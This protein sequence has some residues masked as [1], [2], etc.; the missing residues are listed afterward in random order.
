[1]P[2]VFHKKAPLIEAIK[3]L[4]YYYILIDFLNHRGYHKFTYFRFTPIFFKLLKYV[5]TNGKYYVNEIILN[6][7]KRKPYLDLEKV[8][9]SKKI[10]DEARESIIENLQLNIITV[11][12]HYYNQTIT[13]QDILILDSS[14]KVG[15]GYKLSLH[16]IISSSSKNLFYLNSRYS[17]SSAFHLYTALTS[18]GFLNETSHNKHNEL[19]DPKVYSNDVNFRIIGSHKSF[20]SNRVLRPIHCDTFEFIDLTPENQLNYLLTYFNPDLENIQL[21]TPITDTDVKS[22]D[23]FIK[24][25]VTITKDKPNKTNISA[26]LLKLVQKYHPTASLTSS[27]L[28]LYGFN[29]ENRKEPCPLS[30]IVHDGNNGFYVSEYHTGYLMRCHS[31]NCQHCVPLHIGYV[32]ECD[33]LIKNAI[34]VETPFLLDLDTVKEHIDQWALH[35]FI[36]AIK[37][38]MATGKTTT[39]KYIIEKYGFKQILWISHRQSLTKNLKGSFKKLGFV[40]YLSIKGCLRDYD[41]LFVQIDSIYRIRKLING[42]IKYAYPKY[43]LVIIDEI[44]GNLSHYNSPFLNTPQ[45][46]AREIFDFVCEIISYSGKLLV[47]DADLGSRTKL[48]LEH[49]KSFTLIHNNFRPAPKTFRITNERCIFIDAILKDL[50]S[51]HNVCI[52]SMS[53]TELEDIEQV[54]IQKNIKYVMH[55]SMTDDK[56]KIELEDVNKFWI[57]FQCV[58]YSPTIESGIDF[59]VNHFDSIYG[60]LKDGNNTCS[61]RSFFQMI[62]RIRKCKNSTIFCYYNNLHSAHPNLLANIYTYDNILEYYTVYET[63]NNH[64]VLLYRNTQ[65]IIKGN[66]II[67]IKKQPVLSL[68]DNI[69]IHNDVEN[70]NHDSES[71]LTVFNKLIM[72]AGNKLEF[73]Y[74]NKKDPKYQAVLKLRNEYLNE[75]PEAIDTSHISPSCKE[76]L[77]S[78]ILNVNENDHNINELNKKRSDLSSAEKWVLKRF[79]Y[80]KLFKLKSNVSNS[81]FREYLEIYFDDKDKYHR[82]RYLFGYDPPPHINTDQIA[83]SKEVSRLKI[84]VDL[85]NLLTGSKVTGL[86]LPEFD[87]IKLS[88]KRYDNGIKRIVEQSIYFKNTDSYRPLFFPSKT[89]ARK[90]K[91]SNSK[92]NTKIIVTQFHKQTVLHLFKKYGILLCRTKRKKINGNVINYYKLS[93]ESAYYDINNGQ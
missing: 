60:I 90:K 15:G 63:L 46:S 4:D 35:Q 6:G 88:Q 52:C 8:Y 40:D 7:T 78:H 64:K 73:E 83:H 80:R 17:D 53:S 33:E 62:G 87:P 29:Y 19:L 59:N 84:I 76:L 32:D 12:D 38:A 10:A 75:N 36:L 44:E 34:Q 69:F 89:T 68:F 71:F 24:P 18:C 27:K 70:M 50:D 42:D 43:D 57:Q 11:F 20:D 48:F 81:V 37:S 49:F 22:N 85:Y 79:Y 5:S 72:R 30:D 23:D 28:D 26:Y 39:I 55:T 66:E 58:M 3:Q 31:P 51:H 21:K 86:V 45:H 74:Y 13:K 41:R 25:A 82:Y 91:S 54:L 92:K 9:P 77:I 56:L 14:G 61:Q 47:L 65:K 67:C 2:R 93:L 1:M 16:F